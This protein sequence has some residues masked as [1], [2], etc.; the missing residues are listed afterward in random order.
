MENP[1]GNGFVWKGPSAFLDGRVD[2]TLKR[3]WNGLISLATVQQR[4][5]EEIWLC[6]SIQNQRMTTGYD[7]S[8]YPIK[9]Q[10]CVF[11]F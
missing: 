2:L 1:A 10:I 7:I 6:K 8:I 4:D 3:G 11:M 5:Y 9:L